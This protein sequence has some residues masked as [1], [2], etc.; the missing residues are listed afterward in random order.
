MRGNEC[1]AAA[2]QAFF[3]LQAP[4]VRS[5]AIFTHRNS[6]CR[7]TASVLSRRN[8]TRCGTAVV[9]GKWHLGRC[10]A[11]AV[12]GRKPTRSLCYGSAP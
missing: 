5:A 1:G 10:G 6:A 9:F 12:L 8:N 11:A 7:G 2:A 4:A 3:G